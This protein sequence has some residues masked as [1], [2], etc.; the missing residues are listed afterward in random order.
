MLCVRNIF[1]I[2][3]NNEK[4]EMYSLL[5]LSKSAEALNRASLIKLT[6][7]EISVVNRGEH[8]KAIKNIRTRTGEK[9]LVCKRAVDLYRLKR[10][11]NKGMI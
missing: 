3:T 2:M 6:K 5:W 7:E 8:I 4:E 1:E 11:M 9:L 10:D